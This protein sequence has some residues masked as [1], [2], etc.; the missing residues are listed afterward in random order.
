MEGEVW[1][2]VP[3]VPGVLV[4][5]EGRVMLLP[6]RK[7]MHHG[8]ERS[9]GGQPVRGVWNKPLPPASSRS[10]ARGGFVT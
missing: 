2:D 7:L 3:S 4:S 6:Y 8:G 1:R 9:Y 10:A 5:S